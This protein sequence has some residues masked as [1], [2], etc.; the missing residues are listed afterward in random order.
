V[1]NLAHTKECTCGWK[2]PVLA[3]ADSTD[4]KF[5]D[6]TCPDC[7]RIW[8]VDEMEAKITG[9]AFQS[10]DGGRKEIRE[11]S[12][13]IDEI[14]LSSAQV[15]TIRVAV[16]SWLT[17]LIEEPEECKAL[18]EIGD[19]YLVRLREIEEMLVVRDFRLVACPG[20]PGAASWGRCQKVS[21]H[22][23]PCTYDPVTCRCGEMRMIGAHLSECPVGKD[24]KRRGHRVW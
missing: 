21:G 7:K 23:P 22:E 3:M 13:T 19:L 4:Y 1:K 24:M 5:V 14:S 11:A 20:T 18:G 10:E 15:T 2:F 8:T 12:V 17:R 16:T 6:V 9:C